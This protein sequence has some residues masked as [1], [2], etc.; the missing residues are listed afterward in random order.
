M[1]YQLCG[2]DIWEHV[3][4]LDSNGRGYVCVVMLQACD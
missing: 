1:L 3:D 4:E 2:G